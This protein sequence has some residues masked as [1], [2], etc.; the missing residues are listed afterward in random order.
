MQSCLVVHYSRAGTT[1]GVAQRIAADCA[2]EI[3][4]I[5]ETRP[6]DGLPRYLRSI[7]EAVTGK[8]PEIQP[9]ARTPGGDEL[10]I[11]G[12][13]VWAGHVSQARA[14]ALHIRRGHGFENNSGPRRRVAQHG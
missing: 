3:V 7:Y 9:L 12:T 5:R 11:L 4:R 13:P 2:R 14:K 1:E 8:L 10:V 6:R